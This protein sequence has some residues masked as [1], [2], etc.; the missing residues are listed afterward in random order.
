MTPHQTHSPLPA[1][2]SVHSRQSSAEALEFYRNAVQALLDAKLPFLVG[3]G[4]ALHAYCGIDRKTKDL[5][6]FVR[7]ADVDRVLDVLAACGY[8]TEVHNPVWLAKAHRGDDFVDIIFN[9]G[10]GC[11]AVDDGWFKHAGEAEVL[12]LLLKICP[13]EETIWQKTYI[14]ER[15][16]CD[17]TDVVHLLRCCAPSLDWERLLNRFGPHWRLL[18]AQL[19]IFGFVYPAERD[20]VPDWLIHG[21]VQRLQRDAPDQA[22]KP[23]ICWGT[24]ISRD[25][26]QFDLENWGYRD[27]RIRTSDGNGGE[28]GCRP[29]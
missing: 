13:L 27:G 11:C 29:S 28:A 19:V 10:N 14:F 23:K 15:D 25:Q 12:G 6:L 21:L 20:L 3:G 16:R 4:Y 26:F 17:V 18:L 7:P 8:R 24:L 9:A 1:A 5:D 22:A 2:H